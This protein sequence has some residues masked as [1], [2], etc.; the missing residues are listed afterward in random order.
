MQDIERV[1]SP[2][3]PYFPEDDLNGILKIIADILKSGWYTLG[4][5]TKI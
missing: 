2:A 4:P 1:I 3:K 5:Y